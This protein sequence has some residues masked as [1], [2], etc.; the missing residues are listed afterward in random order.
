MDIETNVRKTGN[1]LGIL[2]PKEAGQHFRVKEGDAIY[3]TKAPD[4]ALHIRTGD[5][6]FE[7]KMASAE[8]G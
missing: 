2:L 6:V 1:S 5:S 7:R 4:N 8:T 3:R